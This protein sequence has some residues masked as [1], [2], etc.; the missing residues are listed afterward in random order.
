MATWPWVSGYEAFYKQKLDDSAHAN[1]IRWKLEI[2]KRPAVI[3]ALKR[4]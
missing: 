2:G 3:R 1:V 4:L